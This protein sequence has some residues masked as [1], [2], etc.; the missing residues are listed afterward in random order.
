MMHPG[1]VATDAEQVH[2]LIAD[3]FPQWADRCVTAIPH[4][5][6]DH[7]LYRLG[8]DLLVRLPRIAW[9]VDQVATDYQ[10]LPVIA[11]YVSAPVP[12][13]VARGGPGRGFPWPWL[14]VP[15][16]SGEN[17]DRG[18]VD[19]EVLAADL[20]TFIVGLHAVPPSDGP[21]KVESGRGAPLIGRDE[22]TRTAIDEL[23]DRIDQ[24]RVTA[25][26]TAALAT[27]VWTRPPVWLH[28][29]I[30]AGNLLVDR[31]RLSAVI[32]FGG[33]GRGDPA[34]D[35]MPAWSLFDGRSRRLFRSAVGYDDATWRRGA[36]WALSTGLIALPYY[37]NT[38]PAFVA[39]ARRK[40]A[41]AIVDLGTVR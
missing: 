28:G 5:G 37:W 14:V 16:L 20:A 33:L 11:R 12:V 6:T 7:A 39:E 38:A 13:P 30:Q 15:W 27:P 4:T 35:L 19:P 32:D 21:L 8:D 36:G 9:A 17:P 24:P 23:G 22:A 18:N 40:I 3:Q 1:E 25:A 26:W 31:A 29:D 41:G 2:G 34:V 10:W